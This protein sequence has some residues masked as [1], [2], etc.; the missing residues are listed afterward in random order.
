MRSPTKV[1]NRSIPISDS[2]GQCKTRQRLSWT[3]KRVAAAHYKKDAL[4][5]CWTSSSDIS[6]YHTDFHEGHGTMGS[7]QGRGM[8]T[9][10]YVWIGLKWLGDSSCG[11]LMALP[12]S[13]W[14]TSLA[15]G[16]LEI[17]EPQQC[18]SPDSVGFP[19]MWRHGGAQVSVTSELQSSCRATVATLLARTHSARV[20]ADLCGNQLSS[21]TIFHSETSKCVTLQRVTKRYIKFLP[22]IEYYEKILYEINT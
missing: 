9:A 1:V 20:K 18:H 21:E 13:G 8:G 12:S 11:L 19:G 16:P 7:W 10:C 2:G 22:E 4:L 14:D 3:R 17:N 15:A 6:G 5:Y